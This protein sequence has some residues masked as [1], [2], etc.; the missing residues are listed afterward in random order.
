MAFLVRFINHFC[1]ILNNFSTFCFILNIFQASQASL[2]VVKSHSKTRKQ[3]IEWLKD[4]RNE[5][6]FLILDE[7]W[8]SISFQSRNIEKVLGIEFKWVRPNKFKSRKFNSW[9]LTTSHVVI[10][11]LRIAQLLLLFFSLFSFLCI[12][13]I[14][15]A[16]PLF[17][18]D[19]PCSRN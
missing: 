17:S 2:L 19:M 16:I 12:F 1:M 5:R 14:N 15:D 8:G 11:V 9:F 3:R 7:S 10:V 6:V 4:W 13:L 18:I